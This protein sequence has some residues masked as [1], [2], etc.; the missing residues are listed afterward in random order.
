MPFV[1]LRMLLITLKFGI[2]QNY[3]SERLLKFVS[4]L[5]TASKTQEISTFVQKYIDLK[6]S[7][8]HTV[9]LVTAVKKNDYLRYYINANFTDE[10]NNSVAVRY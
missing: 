9:K 1:L 10:E 3:A 4:K 7:A 5:C 6:N 8:T 2:K